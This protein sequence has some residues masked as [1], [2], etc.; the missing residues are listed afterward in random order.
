MKNIF[1]PLAVLFFSV[2]ACLA[3]PVAVFDVQWGKG[4]QR[5]TRI[6]AIAFYDLD[7]PQTT[8]NFKKLVQDGF[9]KN[10]TFHRVFPNY[11]VQGGDPLSKKKDRT[12]IGTGGPGYTLRPEIRRKHLRGAVAMGRLPDNVNPTRQSNGSQFYVCLQPI[13]TQDGQD[14]VFGEV[15]AGLE[16]LDEISRL[17]ADSNANPLDRVEIRRTYII[18]RSQLGHPVQ[19]R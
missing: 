15:V 8:A 12:V 19:V 5:Q 1:V 16:A 17:P 7:A 13:T 10:T 11:L 14:T 3:D 18:D 6:F 9:Y 2:V 4:R